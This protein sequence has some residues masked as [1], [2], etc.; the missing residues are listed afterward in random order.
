MGRD[1]VGGFWPKEN[2]VQKTVFQLI[3]SWWEWNKNDWTVGVV[4]S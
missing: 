3:G 1:H 4:G 2:W